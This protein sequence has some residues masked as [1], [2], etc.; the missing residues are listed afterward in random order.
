MGDKEKIREAL[1]LI[2]EVME[3]ETDK[4]KRS[5]LTD[6]SYDLHFY[7]VS[8]KWWYVGG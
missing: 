3:N 1:R 8:K 6:A 4:E 5:V 2:H 7:G